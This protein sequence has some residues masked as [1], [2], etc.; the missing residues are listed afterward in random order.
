MGLQWPEDCST[1]CRDPNDVSVLHLRV[2]NKLI[3]LL[4]VKI[5]MASGI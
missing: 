2:N 4:R 5:V 3:I 1:V